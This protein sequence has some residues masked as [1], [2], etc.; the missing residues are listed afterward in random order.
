[1]RWL[2]VSRLGAEETFRWM[3]VANGS[4]GSC[5]KVNRLGI[6]QIIFWGHRNRAWKLR[7]LGRQVTWDFW[8]MFDGRSRRKGW[9]STFAFQKVA[10]SDLPKKHNSM[11]MSTFAEPTFVLRGGY[12]PMP[13]FL[14]SPFF[15][16][17]PRKYIF[18]AA[19]WNS[20]KRITQELFEKLTGL[21][22]VGLLGALV[23][24][25]GDA[26]K[27]TSIGHT[28]SKKEPYKKRWWDP[29]MISQE[30][31]Q[32]RMN[33]KK[34]KKNRGHPKKK[35]S[36]TSHPPLHPDVTFLESVVFGCFFPTFG[37]P[38]DHWTWTET[39]WQVIGALWYDR[40]HWE[41]TERPGETVSG[42]FRGFFMGPIAR[43]KTHG[44][45]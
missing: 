12:F 2:T 3:E 30:T 18:R 25:F 27:V 34:R 43:A 39:S 8:M 45:G 9:D 5:I 33:Q 26:W 28:T 6:F 29:A 35:Q 36:K 42:W 40:V 22:L 32:Q 17:R 1:M 16:R 11:L 41:E 7:G 4:N 44:I 19:I 14:K 24:H 20:E 10:T 37:G 31:S 38:L 15:F 13:P 21:R 23:G